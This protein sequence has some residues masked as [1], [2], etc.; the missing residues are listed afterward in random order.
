MFYISKDTELTTDLLQML[1]D[2]FKVKN[3]PAGEYNIYRWRVGECKNISDKGENE[4]GEPIG[5]LVKVK[6]GSAKV[7]VTA[8]KAGDKVD[9]IL[10]VKVK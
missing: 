5:K 4:W 3:L 7:E 10:L 2:K 6:K 9:N 8:E 1:I